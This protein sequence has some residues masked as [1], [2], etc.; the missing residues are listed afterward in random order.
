MRVALGSDHAGFVYKN[1]LAEL[2]RSEG[3]TVTDLGTYND[4]PCDYPDI[5]R[6][7]A[8]SIARGE[9]DRGVLLCGS[10][11]GA[12]VAANKVP[13]IRAGNVSDIYSA[14]QG[15]EHDD[16]NILVLGART[17]GIEVAK[18]LVRGFLKAQFSGESRHLNRLN[19]I[20]DIEKDYGK[21]TK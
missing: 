5:A 17:L 2:V 6:A 21:G 10:G 1:L 19:K 11:I 15:V 13:G 4:E 12:S 9:S 18:E 8:E 14:H 16:M 7:V 3:H 20:E